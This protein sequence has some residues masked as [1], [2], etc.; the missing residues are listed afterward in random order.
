MNNLAPDEWIIPASLK[1]RPPDPPKEAVRLRDEMIRAGTAAHVAEANATLFSE[2]VRAFADR[3]GLDPVTVL[4]RVTAERG[5]LEEG[6]AYFSPSLEDIRAGDEALQRDSEAWGKTVDKF[7]D[8]KL[9]QRRQVTIL[10]QTPLVLQML[11]AENR[12][13]NASLHLLKDGLGEYHNLPEA[14][15]IRQL[16][17]AM[18]DPIMVF[19]SASM[20]GD[21]VM[22]LGLKDQHGATVIVPVALEQ[23]GEKGY[24]VNLA[25]SVYGQKDTKTFKPKNQWFATQIENGNLL[26]QNKQKSRDCART[27]K[28]QLPGVNSRLSTT[29][30]NTVHTEADLVKLREANPTMYQPGARG[31]RPDP[32]AHRHPSFQGRRPFH[33]PPRVR[34]HLPGQP[35][36][37]CRRRRHAGQGLV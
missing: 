22:M 16:P 32:G 6:E 12:R 7:K 31:G 1:P 28:L 11:G 35:D 24:T 33:H 15:V 27:A 13:L 20:G 2:H 25:A 18:A 8:G 17:K 26:Y 37:R 9:M 3:Y 29:A 30:R 10:N 14:D 23:A 4:R 21:F 5:H 19:K 36:A 34:A